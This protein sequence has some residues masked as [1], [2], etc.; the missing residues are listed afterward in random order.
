MD[1]NQA[2][3]QIPN[4]P[5]AQN[6][7]N[8]PMQTEIPTPGMTIPNFSVSQNSLPVSHPLQQPQIQISLISTP[9]QPISQPIPQQ[10][11]QSTPQ[12]IQPTINTIPQAISQQLSQPIPT[13]QIPNIPQPQLQNISQ[14]QLDTPNSPQEN[15]VSQQNETLVSEQNISQSDTPLK[16]SSLWDSEGNETKEF[17][18]AFFHEEHLAII[19]TYKKIHRFFFKQGIYLFI[20]IACL[21]FWYQ[22]LTT[23]KKNYIP[24]YQNYQEETDQIENNSHTNI[25]YDDLEVLIKVWPLSINENNILQTENNLVKFQ[26]LIL[27]NN[28]V[29]NLKQTLFDEEKFNMGEYTQEELK[30]LLF[31]LFQEGESQKLENKTFSIQKSIIEDFNLQCIKNYSPYPLICNKFFDNFIKY[32]QFYNLE[33]YTNDLN[34]IFLG[35]K[36]NI[37]KK[38]DFCQ[39]LLKYSVYQATPAESLDTLLNQCSPEYYEQ[40]INNKYI[41]SINQELD[42]KLIQPKVYNK[43]DV[44]AYKTIS[45]MTLLYNNF[46]NGVYNTSIINN[47]LEFIKELINKDSYTNNYLDPVYK[48]L[49]YYFNTNILQTKLE[50]SSNNHMTKT[51]INTFVNKITEINKGDKTFWTIGLEKQLTIKELIN[52]KQI[53]NSSVYKIDIET[54]LNAILALKNLKI[55]R[56]LISEDKKEVEIQTQI[57]FDQYPEINL[58]AKIYLYLEDN[59]LYLKDIIIIEND[60]I[61]SFLRDHNKIERYTLS[62]MLSLLNDNIASYLEK[63]QET[64]NYCN[65]FLSEEYTTECNGN[66]LQIT[67]QGITYQFIF[68]NNSL[69]TFSISDKEKEDKIKKQLE[70]VIFKEWNTLQIIDEILKDSEEEIIVEEENEDTSIRF[71]IK[72]K[73]RDYLLTNAEIQKTNNPNIYEVI[74]TIKDITLK[75]NYDITNHHLTNIYYVINE[76]ET[77]I[78]RKLELILS[79]ENKDTLSYIANNP[80]TYLRLFNSAAY[81]KYERL[82]NG[83]TL[84]GGGKKSS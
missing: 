31:K 62:Q 18:L 63:E 30:T 37:K 4:I 64:I 32:G 83:I 8:I 36:E 68:R 46:E 81:D 57:L 72:G 26:G 80:R 38:S 82:M 78:I 20:T 59:A 43:K 65:Y 45:L 58:K 29:I 49:I 17:H 35:I 13:V 23:S 47:Y 61:T 14:P 12:N 54:P 42:Q 76:K 51:E 69:S 75:A 73:I 41:L 27:W 67:K 19:K 24:I 77:L 15:Q 56:Y 50:N 25:S 10:I 22:F 34:Q 5:N 48:D 66:E 11:T 28:S 33:D 79:E 16:K 39:V 60:E 9:S 44:N 71:I 84:E 70:S 21:I 1:S 3:P 52:Y 2:I 6:I 55:S 74:F 7:P 53:N 40:Y